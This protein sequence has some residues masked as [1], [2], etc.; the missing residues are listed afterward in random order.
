M[1]IH[2]RQVCLVT[3]ALEPSV[4]SIE[5]VLRLPVCHRDPDVAAFGL[6]NALFAL[7]SQFLEVVAPV[8]DAPR[9]GASWSVAAAMAATW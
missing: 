9:P 8:R 4:R 3:R 7:G 1:P 5:S 6:E 2:L